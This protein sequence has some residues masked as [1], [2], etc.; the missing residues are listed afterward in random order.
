MYNKEESIIDFDFFY[1]TQEVECNC[2]P[3]AYGVP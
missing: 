1:F 3:H 2:G